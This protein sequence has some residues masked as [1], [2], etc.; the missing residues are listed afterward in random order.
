MSSVISLPVT[1]AKAVEAD[2]P[3]LAEINALAYLK[4]MIMPILL[5][6]WPN[7]APLVSYFTARI[8]HY[9]KDSNTDLYKIFDS[10]SNEVLGFVCMSNS[11][12]EKQHVRQNNPGG[13]FE[14]PA[15]IGLNFEFATALVQI[16]AKLEECVKGAKHFGRSFSQ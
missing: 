9:L 3:A 5:A 1:V 11:D 7:L 12:G 2:I 6:D 10:G 15:E 8:A 4:E 14:P 16:I 13:D